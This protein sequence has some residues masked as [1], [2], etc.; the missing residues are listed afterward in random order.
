MILFEV[1][2]AGALNMIHA[3]SALSIYVLRLQ[4]TDMKRVLESTRNDVM[5]NGRKEIKT[6]KENNN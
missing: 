6:C 4:Q 3:M 1:L 5:V 2:I